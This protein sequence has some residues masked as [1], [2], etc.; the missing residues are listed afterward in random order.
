VKSVM[1]DFLKIVFDFMLFF[2]QINGILPFFANFRLIAELSTPFVRLWWL[3][4]QCGYDSNHWLPRLNLLILISVFGFLRVLL[5]PIFWYKVSS[6]TG[7]YEFE[8]LGNIRHV[9]VLACVF[10]DIINVSCDE[11][12]WKVEDFEDRLF[13][14]LADTNGRLLINKF[15]KVLHAT[16]LQDNDPR[17]R[18]CMENFKKVE[19]STEHHEHGGTT[20]DKETFKECI[21]DNI[22]LISR[23]VKNSFIIPDFDDFKAIIHSLYLDAKTK[24]GGKVASYIPQLARYSPEYWGVSVCTV[25]GQR[26]SLGDVDIPFC[27][28]SCSKPLT[29]ALAQ[30]DFTPDYV[31][32]YVGHEPSGSSFNEISLNLHNKPHNP[33]INSGAILVA[34]LIRPDLKMADRFDYITNYFKKLTGGEFVAFNNSVYLS[35]KDTA[36]RNFALGYY[37]RENDCFPSDI[38]FQEVMEFY[39]QICSIEV[40]CESAAVIAATLANGGYCPITDEKILSASS[41][42]N[43][44]SLM[45]SCGLYDWS[46]EFAFTVGLPGKSGVSGCILLVVPNVMGICIWSP[47]LD[48]FGNSVRGVH[49]CQSLVGNF[50]FHQ[51][52][53]VAHNPKKIDPTKN[54]LEN[55][56]MDVVNVLFGAFSGDVTAVRRYY[57]MGIDMNI[58]DYDGRT[59]LHLAASEGHHDVVKFLTDKCRCDPFA[60]DSEEL[61]WKVEDFE[62]RLF[63]TL[64]DSDGRLLVKKFK[65]VLHE[66]GLRDNDPRLR[67][68]MNNFKKAQ[69]SSDNV[70]QGGTVDRKT[71][72]ECISDNIMLISRAVKNSF[73]IPD[74]NDFKDIIHKLYLECK[75]KTGGKVASYIPQLARYS[76][77][78]WGVSICT[79]DGQRYGYNK[80]QRSTYQLFKSLKVEKSCSKPLTYA[81]AQNDYN[82]DYVHKYVGHEPSGRSFN[83]ISLNLHNKPH[84]P[85]INSG[86]IMMAS[87]IR[88]D[89]KMADRYDYITKYIK[90]LT[91]G[92]YVAFNNSVY[93][94]EK[95]TADRNFALGYYM[96]EN[97]VCSIEVNCDSASVIAATLANGGY[98]PITDEKILSPS[99]VR[100]T[101]SLMHS[102]GLYDWS[103]Q[104]AFE[105]GLP[106]KSGVSGCILLV[107]PNVMGVCMWSPPLDKFGN[108]VRGVHFCQGLVGN[109][110]FHQFDNVA[111]NLKKI[112]PTKN[113]LENKA[114]DVFNVLFG[115][116]SGDVTAV[117]RYYL[118]G[119]NMDIQDYDGRTA[120]HLAAS[121][122]HLDVVKFLTEKCNCDP[123]AKDREELEFKPGDFEDKL[124]DTLADADGRVLIKKFKKVASYIPQLARYSPD[125]W[126]VSICTVDGQRYSVGDVNVPFCL[127]STSKP[128]TYALA[129]NDFDPEYVHK[130][131]GHE[132]SGRSFNEISLNTQNKPHNPMINSGAIMMAS[133]VRPDLKMA[134]RYDYMCKYIKKLT[135]G[136]YVAFNNSVYLSE[137]DTADRNFALGYYM[138]ENDCFP[139]DI[140]F[141]EIMEFYF[142]LCSIEVTCDSAAVIAATLANGGYCPITDEKILSASS[143]RN[144]LSLMHSCG[145]YDWSGEFAFTVGLP[146]KSGVSGCVLLVVPNVMGICVWS[147][148]LDKFGNSVR[149]VHFC[150]GLVNNFN[151]HQFDKVTYDSKKIDPT[152]NKL[153]NRAMDVFNVLFGAFSGDV[154]AVRR[155]YLLGIDMDIQDYDGRTALHLAA[156]EGHLDCIKF[157]TEKCNCDPFAKDSEE[158]DWKAEDFEDRL[159]DTLADSDGRVLIKKFKKILHETGLRDSDPR[160]KQCMNNFKKVQTT[161]ESG[162]H[163]GTVDRKSFK[164]CISDNIMLISKAV[165]NSFIIPDFSDFKDII[166][167]LYLE[168]KSK[169]GGQVASYI[170]QLARYSPE[171]WAVS[172]CTIDGQRLVQ[173]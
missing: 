37:M 165:K 83:E 146:G 110:N 106:G 30:N 95:D 109:F 152:K 104:F 19:S 12:D 130:Y 8:D 58:Q 23:A 101:L 33:M 88:P 98:C 99:S 133:L 67:Q 47:P 113:K 65:K 135:G 158:L 66:T 164:E 97:D 134:D 125:L 85:M 10:L 163:G 56:A 127:Q 147:P 142:Q 145:M 119:I 162:E 15:K 161:S 13:D 22:M 46:G 118:L 52:D 45:H 173:C 124:F 38:K 63:D 34:S 137:K 148:P 25:D 169:T 71:F 116:F 151:F 160:L 57:L 70:E 24:T 26:Y 14:S 16:G 73:I 69:N 40:T 39:F 60:K 21:S 121:E 32:K 80:H 31:H 111:H 44:L 96:R 27:L 103:G 92:E 7:T 9:V 94:S 4:R 141:Q 166:H 6:I 72:R 87:L 89:L 35:E 59:A 1:F 144:T 61:D 155:Y 105:V 120:L 102:C 122:G 86:A 68:C 51:F 157:L 77:E 41:V 128:L 117:R 168:C 54:K 159:F 154:T 5:A 42:R 153:E 136:E 107:V 29:Y 91:G 156:S 93:L 49:F 100:N 129:Q 84:N 28:Q 75:S 82:P 167:K 17:L 139:P 74:F 79:V 108:S 48:T 132:P 36:D 172:I 170:P 123:F 76:P 3:F 18:Q 64:A 78:L 62:D 112:D 114:M 53:S 171:L 50:N 150:Q 81:L 55:K 2:F 126:A 90:K 11:V 20:V 143:V 43:T 131:V 140:K 115:A 149:G 138:R